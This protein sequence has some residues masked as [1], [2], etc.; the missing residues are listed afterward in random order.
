MFDPFFALLFLAAI[1]AP[2]AALICWLNPKRRQ[3]RRKGIILLACAVAAIF[4]FLYY[5]GSGFMGDQRWYGR[6]VCDRA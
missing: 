1:I 2:A 3:L 6:D 4:G 5:A